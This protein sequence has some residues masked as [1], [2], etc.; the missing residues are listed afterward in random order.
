MSASYV[1]KYKKNIFSNTAAVCILLF[2]GVLLLFA[3]AAEFEFVDYD[4][5]EYVT[6]N[7]RVQE[8]LSLKNLVW[9]CTTMHAANWHPLTW[10]SHMLD[11]E[12]YGLNAGGHHMTSVILHAG[13]TV[14]LYLL[15]AGMTGLRGRSFF[16]AA[17]FAV[18]PLHVESVAWISERKDVLSTFFFFLALLSYVRYVRRRTAGCYLAV[19]LLFTLGLC[20]KPM[21]VTLP[22][23]LLLL[24]W[25]PLKRFQSLTDSAVLRQET[26]KQLLLEKVPLMI[27]SAVS[28]MVTLAAQHGGGA[29]RSLKLFPHDVRIANA[30]AAYAGYIAKTLWP[31]NLALMYPHHGMPPVWKIAGAA[32]LVTIMLYFIV[33]FARSRPWFTVGSLWFFGTLVPVIGLVQVGMQAMA[34][35]YT[36][37]PAIGLFILC[38][39]GIPEAVTRSRHKVLPLPAT[40]A[41]VL[42][43]LAALTWFQLGCWKDS[44]TLFQHSID[45]TDRNYIMHIDMG[46]VLSEKGRLDEAA[47]HYRRALDIDP[48]NIDGLINLGNVYTKWNRYPKAVILYKKALLLKPDSALAR[49]NLG[50]ALAA[51]GRFKSAALHYENALRIN[52]QYA[53]ACNNL[54]IALEETQQAAKAETLYR[55]AIRMDPGYAVAHIN[56]GNVLLRKKR[57]AEAA[58]HFHKALSIDPEMVEAHISLGLVSS[59][60]GRAAAA[61]KHYRSA[62]MFDPDNSKAH[63]S[64]GVTLAALG[65]LKNAEDHYRHALS[66][67]PE[68]SGAHNN[69]GLVL[70]KQGRMEEA[71]GHYREAV[72]L[73]PDNVEA[74]GNLGIALARTGRTDNAI[75]RFRKALSIR[76]NSASIHN[77]LG[78]LLVH[79]GKLDKALTHFREA[80][81]L[82]PQYESAR[83]NIA[84]V[85][86]YQ[87][88]QEAHRKNDR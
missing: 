19:M 67:D 3:P 83:K 76:P 48:E 41:C 6:E 42:A 18:H 65:D 2:F 51:L 70:F 40:A 8:G 63:V 53:E 29:V 26:P 52:P 62:L 84:A 11:C 16:V 22:F 38:A 14:L 28:C 74:H 35:R 66:L 87:N 1:S 86:S 13:S 12:L 7:S 79:Q 49:N 45:V 55:K 34:D 50:L 20:A 59:A 32:A 30:L 4:D 25:W 33:R 9:A 75:L 10:L 82:N 73:Q 27:L 47:E 37:I 78:T 21:I 15:L 58:S 77:N 72:R 61:V 46:L 44:L 17:L 5:M 85:L 80:V 71:I 23:V 56:L 69:L 36:Y 39:W 81:R 68:Y 31:F 88:G 60:T 43:L 54:G 57:F 24:D 64:L